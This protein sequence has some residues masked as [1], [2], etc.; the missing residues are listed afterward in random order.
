MDYLFHIVNIVMIVCAP[1]TTKRKSGQMGSAIDPYGAPEFWTDKVAYR[2][3]A[4]PGV[5]RLV[6]A[7][8]EH[9]ENIIKA[10]ILMP[11]H[12]IQVEQMRTVAFLSSSEVG[13]LVR[14]LM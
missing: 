1:R 14:V 5:I 12:I 9:G 8:D 4:C 11:I 6:F 2:E 3:I 7:A 13:D 10:K